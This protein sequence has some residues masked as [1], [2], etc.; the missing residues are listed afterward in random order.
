MG[1]NRSQLKHFIIVSATLYFGAGESAKGRSLISS[2]R[3]HS[4]R[5][6]LRY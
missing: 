2:P 4:E 1:W 3:I 5:V 6:R